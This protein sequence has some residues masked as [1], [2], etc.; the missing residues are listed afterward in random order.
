MLVV[1]TV[2]G[3]TLVAAAAPEQAKPQASDTGIT[4]KEIHL[5]V[6]ADVDNAAVPGLFQSSVNAMNAWAKIVN[7]KGGLAGRKVVID[8]IDSHLS[9]ND[10]RNGAIKA[11]QEDFAMVGGEAL[12]LSNVDDIVSCPDAQGKATGLPDLPG[13]ALD[14]NERCSPMTYLASG[15]TQFCATKDDHPQTYFSQVGDGRYYKT[16]QKG[17]HGIFTVPADLQATKNAQQ[18]VFDGLV[19]SGAI[20]KDQYFDVTAMAPQ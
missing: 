8:F 16:L 15:D 20:G 11:C 1:A 13:L 18:A 6:V 17:L 2:A 9:A 3:S 19:K 5:A 4:D 10:A 12:F 7:K 14:V